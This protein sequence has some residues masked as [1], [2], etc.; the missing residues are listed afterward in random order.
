MGKRAVV[1]QISARFA[2][3]ENVG[4]VRF[5]VGLGISLQAI[6][7]SGLAEGRVSAFEQQFEVV[8]VGTGDL[9]LLDLFTITTHTNSG[10]TSSH[11]SHE[12]THT[13]DSVYTHITHDDAHTHTAST[14]HT[15]CLTPRTAHSGHLTPHTNNK[16]T[17]HI[18]AP[19]PL[20]K[21]KA[22]HK[23]AVKKDKA[24]AA[25]SPSSGSPPARGTAR[26]ETRKTNPPPNSVPPHHPTPTAPTH[27]P[28][29]AKT[30]PRFILGTR[31]AGKRAVAH[32]KLTIGRA[33]FT[34]TWRRAKESLGENPIENGHPLNTPSSP[35][36]NPPT[37]PPP[38]PPLPRMTTQPTNTP[39]HQHSLFP[40]HANTN[41]LPKHPL[42]P[43]FANP[44]NTPSAPTP[45][46][47]RTNHQPFTNTLFPT[48]TQPQHHKVRQAG[49]YLAVNTIDHVY[50]IPSA[51]D[52][53]A[54][55]GSS[56]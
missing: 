12:H 13:S 36:A 24:C 33:S 26:P 35:H 17:P 6:P 47:P 25:G 46:F 20:N 54:T 48:A 29:Q 21:N 41:T 8:R 23:R 15:R 3:D 49:A 2:R 43:A 1:L 18:T 50:P 51:T 32:H 44:P 19:P 42:L 9:D 28:P 31:D 30:P 38:T 16:H 14:S 40:P 11:S 39:R 5:D 22:K 55:R 10:T 27:H 56:P 4:A 53:E 37:T 34:Y 7:I 45:L 52:F